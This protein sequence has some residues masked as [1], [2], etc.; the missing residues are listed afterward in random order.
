MALGGSI[1]TKKRRRQEIR[2]ALGMSGE[3][4]DALR[5][6]H[7]REPLSIVAAL[8]VAES[9]GKRGEDAI[10]LAAHLARM[11]VDDFKKAVE[12]L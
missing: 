7:D 6:R 5:Q 8:D 1:R 10:V 11:S 2:K 9:Q 12:D 3:F 4:D